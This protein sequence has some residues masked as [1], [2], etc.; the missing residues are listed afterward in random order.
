MVT[1]PAQVKVESEEAPRAGTTPRR[2][3]NQ[4]SFLIMLL[5]AILLADDDWVDGGQFE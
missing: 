5:F 1:S 3:L 2:S 4:R